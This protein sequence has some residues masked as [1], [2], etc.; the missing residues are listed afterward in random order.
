MFLIAAV[1]VA[2]L[3]GGTVWSLVLVVLAALIEV[4]EFFLGLAYV[5]RRRSARVVGRTGRMREDGTVDVAGELWPARGAAAPGERVTVVGVD[6]K[7]LIVTRAEP[8][9]A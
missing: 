6:K 4:G 9:D 2:V 8:S 3:A 7:T 5:R 1:I